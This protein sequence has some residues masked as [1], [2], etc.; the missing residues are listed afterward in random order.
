MDKLT[1]YLAFSLCKSIPKAKQKLLISHLG[2]IDN[3]FNLSHREL[4]T[5]LKKMMLKQP[6]EG[7][8]ALFQMAQTVQ[9]N[10][11][12][13]DISIIPLFDANYP[14]RI[15]HIYDPPLVL[16]VKG[17]LAAW[18]DLKSSQKSFLSIVGTRCPSQYASDFAH[19][20][21]KSMSAKNLSIISGLAL[22]IDTQAHL[23]AI[24]SGKTIA[25]L[26]NGLDGIYPRQN[27][28]LARD[29]LKKDGLLISEHPPG[30]K[31][32]KHHFPLRNRLISGLGDGVLMTEA[33]AKSGALITV[34]YA[35]DQGKEVWVMAP[36]DL[37]QRYTGNRRLIEDGAKAIDDIAELESY[38]NLIQTESSATSSNTAN[39]L[40]DPILFF[41][42]SGPKSI[43]E[44]KAFFKKSGEE[45]Q[46]LMMPFILKGD[47]IE[48]PGNKYYLSFR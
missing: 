39:R 10:C 28:H 4:N 33:K 22:G 44:M 11:L 25:V 48:S 42:S 38:F 19:Y 21:S 3:F 15:K 45:L 5:E 30:V 24:R 7:R 1:K 2:S 17:N 32:L 36:P 13:R 47:I 41:L 8:E 9:Q 14:L 6:F 26:G 29:I 31:P 12:A 27:V 16:Y 23:G 35:L 34:S 20:I 40:K 18:P 37:N 43:L 46:T